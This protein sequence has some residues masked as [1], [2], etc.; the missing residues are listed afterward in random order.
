ML[1]LGESQFCVIKQKPILTVLNMSSMFLVNFQSA[2]PGLSLFLRMPEQKC[3]K[4]R[5]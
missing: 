2:T 3:C 1:C 4:T 5:C